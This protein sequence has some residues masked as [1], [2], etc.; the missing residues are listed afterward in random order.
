[1]SPP[2]RPGERPADTPHA[3]LR[4][5][6]PNVSP[7]TDPRRPVLVEDE[8]L[9]WQ[10]RSPPPAPAPVAIS[11]TIWT[12]RSSVT[13]RTMLEYATQRRRCTASVRNHRQQQHRQQQRMQHTQAD[14]AATMPKNDRPTQRGCRRTLQ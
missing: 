2:T 4:H 7:A 14:R 11:A 5:T 1:M 13:A 9:A 8:L 3:S 10:A 6:T 12:R